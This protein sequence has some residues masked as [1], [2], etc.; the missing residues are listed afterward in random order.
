[1]KDTRTQ[2]ATEALKKSNFDRVSSDERRAFTSAS[3]F[4]GRYPRG[5]RMADEQDAYAT[6]RWMATM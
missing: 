3:I 6:A 2:Q 4:R 5:G 1:M